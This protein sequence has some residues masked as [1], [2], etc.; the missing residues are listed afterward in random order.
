MDATSTAFDD[1]FKGKTGKL[2]DWQ[3]F[4]FPFAELQHQISS[5]A[6][7]HRSSPIL[8]LRV[9]SSTAKKEPDTTL[10]P[11]DTRFGR[12]QKLDLLN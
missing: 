7:G 5:L 9:L 10:Q 1:Q 3:F 4:S 12:T 11:R 6:D 2:L 8:N